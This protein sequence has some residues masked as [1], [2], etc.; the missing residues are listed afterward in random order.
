LDTASLKRFGDPSCARMKVFEI[1]HVSTPRATG[2]CRLLTEVG[3]PNTVV[4]Q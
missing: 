1:C 4:T 2:R 3:A